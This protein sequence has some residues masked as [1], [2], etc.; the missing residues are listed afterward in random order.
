MFTDYWQKF[1]GAKQLDLFFNDWVYTTG[2]SKY[3]NPKITVDDIVNN[4]NENTDTPTIIP[5]TG[6]MSYDYS[7]QGSTTKICRA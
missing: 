3:I 2:Y 4:Y 1:S 7:K 5:P 6:K